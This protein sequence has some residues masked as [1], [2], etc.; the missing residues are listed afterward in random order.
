MKCF[1]ADCQ[2]HPPLDPAEVARIEA[3]REEVRRANDA[4]VEA[5]DRKLFEEVYAE[6]YRSLGAK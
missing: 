4:C 6:V 1:R 3:Q 2:G 5:Y